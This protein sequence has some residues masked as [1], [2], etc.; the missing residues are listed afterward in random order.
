MTR[1]GSRFR[2]AVTGMAIAGGALAGLTVILALA[3]NCKVRQSLPTVEGDVPLQGLSGPVKI[4]RDGSG[5][6]LIEG[7]NRQD[8]ARALGF[9]H[10][11]ERFFQMDLMRRAS[12]GE[13]SELV[14]PGALPMDRE[15]R[16]HRFRHR[17]GE[18]V[19]GMAREDRKV[20]TAYTEGVNAGLEELGGGPFEYMLLRTDPA[21]WTEEDTILVV[22]SMF[23]DLYDG[24]ALYERTLG[25]M[26]DVMDP[27]MVSFLAPLTC[28]PEAPLTGVPMVT[29]PVPGPEVVNIRRRRSAVAL[30]PAAPQSWIRTG[31]DVAVGSNNW[32]VSGKLSGHGRAMV[33]DDMHLGLS[34]PNTW[35]RAMM[36]WPDGQGG[37]TRIVGVTLPGTPAL[38]AGSNTKIAWGLTN[39]YGD[40]TDV[41]LVEPDPTDP[42]S[43]VT[44]T[45]PKKFKKHIEKIAVNGQEDEEFAIRSTIWGPV[46]GTDHLGRPMALRFTAHD[47]GSVN[48][49]IMRLEQASSVEEALTIAPTCGIPPQ[50]FT[51]ADSE[52][53]IGWT[54]AG[55]IP[56]RRG[57][58]GRFP[59]SWADG[60]VGWEGYYGVEEYPRVYDPPS[61]LIWTANARVVS[62]ED[63]TKLGDGHYSLGARAR[64][65]RDHLMDLD[66]PVEKD[67]LGVQLDDRALF[68][69]RWREH[70]LDLLDDEAVKGKAQRASFR[71]LVE[72]SWTGH[73]SVD[74]AGYRLVRNYRLELFYLVWGWLTSDCARSDPD[75][76]YTVLRQW[77]AP[78]WR[79]IEKRPQHLLHPGY[80]SWK[81]AM[82]E[83]VDRSVDVCVREAGSLQQ[84]TWG[85]RNTTDIAHP[86]THAVGW[87]STWLNMEPRQLPGDSHMPR[88]QA[89]REGASERFVISPGHEQDAI[90]HMPCGQS[91]HPL[92]DHYGDGHHAW[93]E[94]L[95]TPLLPGEAVHVLTLVPG[96]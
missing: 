55:R 94:G 52:G 26:N 67:L 58:E 71:K 19:Q 24:T 96:I 86:I 69:A 7:Q 20:L 50:N 72:D 79:L 1:R 34:V 75:F 81:Q 8:V 76:A 37:K 23:L 30:P 53:H 5:V 35:Y 68:L 87:L 43:Y 60:S 80:D 36:V 16:I 41:V 44:T 49:N 70:L 27:A 4:S 45:G 61:G 12:A 63:L 32:A 64:Q 73:A 91:G 93:E 31:D 2:K 54:I 3:G 42:E 10:G 11:Q 90:F 57:F 95:P 83:A 92:S 66:R 39:S 77:E 14:G 62:G 47:P 84:C 88:F 22:Y 15:S 59:L 18:I 40:Y 85:A 9:V 51:C 33:A 65:I 74:S 29:P 38:V 28:E 25:V 78:M 82:L 6:P 48:L 17:A 89:P 56:R 13:I 46:I 21:P